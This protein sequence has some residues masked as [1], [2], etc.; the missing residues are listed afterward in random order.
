VWSVATE[1]NDELQGLRISLQSQTEELP[2]SRKKS[3][4]VG[5]NDLADDRLSR[6]VEIHRL[7][8]AP[9]NICVRINLA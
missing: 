9:S 1:V 7:G 4:N 6:F 8:F 2:P 5:H 3:C